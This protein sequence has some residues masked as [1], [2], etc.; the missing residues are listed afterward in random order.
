MRAETQGPYREK[1]ASRWTFWA[2]AW[3]SRRCSTGWRNSTRGWRTPTS[4]TIPSAR[5]K[6]MRDRQLLVDQIGTY[7][8]IRSGLRDNS[9]LIEL[10]EA[11]GDTEV[12]AEAEAALA[13]L[14]KTAAAKELEA[15]LDGEA[16][17]N[18]TFLEINAGGG[19]HR[20][21][22]LGRYASADV[23]PLGPRK[24][25]LRGGAAIGKL[26]RR[27]GDQIGCLTRSRATTPH[28]L[29]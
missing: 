28:V 6:L 15:L 13:D 8:A 7:E 17:A 4:G 23:H 25:R 11:E 14:A 24:T 19:R 9:E 21:L 18:D 20:K 2:S 27:G 5:R 29:G 10:G 26:R 22:R 3:A 12:V 16:D 1:F